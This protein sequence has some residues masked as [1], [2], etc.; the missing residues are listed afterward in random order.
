MLDRVAEAV[1]RSDPGVAAPGE[2]QLARA[3]HADHLVVDE[4]G[5][6]PDQGEVAAP[7]ADDLVPGGERDQVR[8]PFQGHAVPV[9]DEFP[10]RVG[11]RHDLGHHPV[12]L[13]E[14]V[15]P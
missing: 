1:Q 6:H 10:D 8:E 14:P 5:S 13:P 15:A 7:L 4:V 3:S 2:H 9:V 11:E 12:T